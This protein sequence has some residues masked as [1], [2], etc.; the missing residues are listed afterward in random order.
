MQWSSPLS[1]CHCLQTCLWW[2]WKRASRKRGQGEPQSL[3]PVSSIAPSRGLLPAS[4]S[5]QR[6]N[7]SCPFLWEAGKL[8]WATLVPRRSI[9]RAD[10]F[11]E[12]AAVWDSFTPS[13]FLPTLLSMGAGLTLP[14]KAFLYLPLHLCSFVH[15]CLSPPSAN[16]LHI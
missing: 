12:C 1:L 6:I 16:L 5:A 8:W 10:N 7:Y 14:S 15:K 9:G 4:D 11:L 3:L 2:P 13:P